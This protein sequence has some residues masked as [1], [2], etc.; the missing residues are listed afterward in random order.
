VDLAADTVELALERARAEEM[1]LMVVEALRVQAMIA[2]RLEQWDMAARSLE[3]GLPLARSM[4]YPYAEARLLQLYG[5]LHTATG[6]PAAARERLEAARAI[7]AR[8][9]A[10]RDT[11]RVE[12]ALDALSQNPRLGRYETAVSD[13][14][15]AQVQALLPPPART[16]RRRAD[17][18]RTL[19]GILYQRR[20]GCAW[21]ALPAAFGDEA[22]AHRRLQQWQAAGLWERIAAL[23]QPLPATG[24]RRDDGP[25]APASAVSVLH[26]GSIR[27]GEY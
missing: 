10:W 18:R 27:S 8:L 5:E 7:F 17:D 13:A 15:W 3:E 1:R 4:P 2:L 25:G 6:K 22:T 24:H 20:T 9:G 26:G 21:A 16:G 12:H 19:E 23:V 11:E 14:Q